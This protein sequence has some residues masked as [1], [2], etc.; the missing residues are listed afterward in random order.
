M[1]LT[2]IVVELR[3]RAREV[4]EAKIITVEID[5]YTPTLHH[6][7]LADSVTSPSS[8]QQYIAHK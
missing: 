4:L 5:C 2:Q 8:I 1:M 7:G 6:R 3:A